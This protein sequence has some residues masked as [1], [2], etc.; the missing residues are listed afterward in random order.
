MLYKFLCF[1]LNVH[2]NYN[3][4]K[5][6]INND[7]DDDNMKIISNNNG[8]KNIDNNNSNDIN[9]TSYLCV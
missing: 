7:Q 1:F 8:S 4:E 3:N 5:Y 6:D 9:I 2:I